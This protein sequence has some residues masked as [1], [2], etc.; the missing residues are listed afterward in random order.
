[1]TTFDFMQ[2]TSLGGMRL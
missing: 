1:M 2:L